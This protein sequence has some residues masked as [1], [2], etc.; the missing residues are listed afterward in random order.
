[1][2]DA[3]EVSGVFCR[4]GTYRINIIFIVTIML[5]CHRPL[6]ID[7]HEVSFVGVDQV[8]SLTDHVRGTSFK[9][10]ILLKQSK[11]GVQLLMYVL[12]NCAN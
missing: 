4:F 9:K 2:L 11:L 7:A 12:M 10:R 6:M 5:S 8:E 3:H 1:M